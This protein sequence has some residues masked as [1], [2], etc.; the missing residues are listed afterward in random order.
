MR[1][2]FLGNNWVGWKVLNWLGENQ[3]EIIGLVLHPPE[4]RKFGEEIL[5]SGRLSKDRIFD[6]RQLRQPEVLDAIKN[7]QPEIG[8]SAFFGYILQSEFLK[9][10]PA[11]CV[12]IHSAYQPFNRGSYPNVWSIIE[13][14]PAGVTIHYVDKGVDTGDIINQKKIIVEPVDTGKSLYQKLEKASV[15]L[16]QETWPLIATGGAPR[17]PQD[18]N[19]GTL[20]YARDVNRID[21]IELDRLYPARELIN[22]I[23]ARTFPPHPGAYFRLEGKKIFLRMELLDEEKIAKEKTKCRRSLRSTDAG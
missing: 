12:N 3:E 20:H 7:L 15:D 2:L 5:Q 21:E 11:G 4:K 14:T 6:A 13:G 23:R 9:L 22:L 19:A 10:F 17:I 8:V 16:F 18:K 1:I